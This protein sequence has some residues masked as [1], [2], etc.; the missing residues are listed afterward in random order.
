MEK[1]THIGI[2]IMS[3]TS[4]DGLDLALCEF[5]GTAGGRWQ[6]RIIKA[7]TVPYDE[8]WRSALSEAHQGDALGYFMLHSRFGAFIARQALELA[9]ASVEKPS[10][11]AS[12]GHTVFHRPE[13]G[14]STQ[15]GCGATIA[16]HTRLTTVCDFRSLDTANGGQGAPLVPVGDKLLFPQYTACLNIGGIA[17][18]SFDNSNARR[19]AFDICLANMALNHLSGL[20]GKAY[21]DGGQ[22]AANGRV[23]QPLLDTL[24]ALNR[25]QERRSLA[26]EFFEKDILPLCSQYRQAPH[27]L[28]I[29]DLLATFTEHTAMQVAAVLNQYQL[30]NVLVTGGGA[31]NSHLIERLKNYYKGDIVSPDDHTIQFKEALIFAFLGLLRLQAQTN[32][33]ST[34]TGAASD[35]CGGAVYRMG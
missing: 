13:L 17:N 6:Y 28:S 22:L 33:L 24:N 32:T 1:E 15:V 26:R 35:S 25:Q 12:H 5:T 31:Y 2:G 4:L 21:D 10:F 27:S 20:L 11:I 9:E 30:K 3:G 16:A 19:L 8:A 18:I 29:N 23:C 14:F 34:V 7:R